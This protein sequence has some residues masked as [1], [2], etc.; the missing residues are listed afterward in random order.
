MD[1]KEWSDFMPGSWQEEVNVRDFIQKNYT[2]ITRFY[3][4]FWTNNIDK[5]EYYTDYFF[6]LIKTTT[7]AMI[8]TKT[9]PPMMN[10]IV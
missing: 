6:F 9:T 1:Y 2:N 8:A 10:Q 3:P 7:V 4:L 5:S